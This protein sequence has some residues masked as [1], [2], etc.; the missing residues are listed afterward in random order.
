MLIP[1]AQEH[2]N[3]LAGANALQQFNCAATLAP[4]ENPAKMP[5]LRQAAPKRMA[6]SSLPE[7]RR[8]ARASTYG[9][10]HRITAPGCDGWDWRGLPRQDSRPHRLDDEALME[11]PVLEGGRAA[12]KKLTCR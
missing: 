5:F 1:I 7:C 8:C 2:G 6:S 9:G 4:E 12:A 11:G 3:R 10:R